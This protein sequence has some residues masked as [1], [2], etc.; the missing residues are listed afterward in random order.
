M[1][2][3][4]VLLQ[5]ISSLVSHA[6]TSEQH[7]HALQFKRIASV[8]KALKGEIYGESVRDMLAYDFQAATLVPQSFG[9]GLGT[10]RVRFD[11]IRS[12]YSFLS[13]LRVDYKVTPAPASE[14]A[15]GEESHEPREAVTVSLS[16]PSHPG[17]LRIVLSDEPR[18]AWRT[19]RPCFDVDALACNRTGVYLYT[20][21][22]P[23]DALAGAG[24]A[25]VLGRIYA[26]RFCLTA[27]D[28]TP[29]ETARA[30]KRAV[31]LV[32][33]GWTMDDAWLGAKSWLAAHWKDVPK[34]RVCSE[35][36]SIC[37][38]RFLPHDVAVVLPCQ[39]AFHGFCDQK[40]C[41]GGIC[42][43]LTDNA[44]CPCCRRVL[45]AS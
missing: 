6:C 34:E 30:A 43:W 36:C 44:S 15:S 20:T 19:R 2:A 27:V 5:Q 7:V 40:Y 35:E 31:A 37:Q 16:P 14:S 45:L 8:A 38:E 9:S 24:I 29:R 18:V 41:A 32:R 12:W 11:D 26:R 17:T 42:T 3:P 23:H 4:A 13:V 10:L 33:A 28:P 22:T 21:M 1:S 25:G 39:H